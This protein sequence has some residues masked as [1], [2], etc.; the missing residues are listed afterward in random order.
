MFE[1][2]KQRSRFCNTPKLGEQTFMLL[3][4]YMVE[5]AGR[6]YQIKTHRIKTIKFYPAKL[7]K[8]SLPICSFSNIETFT[9][10]IRACNFSIWKISYKIS[11]RATY[12]TSKIQDLQRDNFYISSMTLH[13]IYLVFR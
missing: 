9:R 1:N 11:Y 10:N 8:I 2:S 6:K 5:H 13:I 12:A 7:Y 3:F 4:R